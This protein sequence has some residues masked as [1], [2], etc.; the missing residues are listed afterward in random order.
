MQAK[1]YKVMN[2]NNIILAFL[3]FVLLLT[4]IS[5]KTQTKIV[6][7]EVPRIHTEYITKTDSV[8]MYDSIYIKE[9]TKA[10]TVYLSEYKFKYIDRIK[11]DTIMKNDTITIVKEVPVEVEVVPERY[12]RVY[13]LFILL[14]LGFLVMI[15]YKIR[16]MF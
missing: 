7:V 6:E 13:N 15:G 10:D 9:Y 11:C 12:R 5:C 16:K 2:R 4:L 8:M 1:K 14:L 3:L